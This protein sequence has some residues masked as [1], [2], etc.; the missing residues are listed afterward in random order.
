MKLTCCMCGKYAPQTQDMYELDAEYVRRYPEMVGTLA[1]RQCA[2]RDRYFE[3]KNHKDDYVPGHV[4]AQ[5]NPH[6]F[7]SWHHI[8]CYGPQEALAVKVPESGVRQGA[9]DYLIGVRAH[10]RRGS[11]VRESIDAALRGSYYALAQ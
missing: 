10:L 2:V 11:E 1:C 6:C 7:D 4:P 5:S 8:I 3:C 9:R